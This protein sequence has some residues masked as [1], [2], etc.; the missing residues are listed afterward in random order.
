ML[1]ACF[2]GSSYVGRSPV[3]RFCG[4]VAVDPPTDGL[5]GVLSASWLLA[6]GF[7]AVGFRP[8]LFWSVEAVDRAFSRSERALIQRRP[9]SRDKHSSDRLLTVP[10]VE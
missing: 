2:L 5:T 9:W 10:S 7:G 3:G 6:G 8:G 4:V 1:R